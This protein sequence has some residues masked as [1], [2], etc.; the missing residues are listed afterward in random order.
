[1]PVPWPGGGERAIRLLLQLCATLLLVATAAVVFFRITI[2]E[3]GLAGGQ[4]QGGSRSWI[5]KQFASV[6]HI[7][8]LADFFVLWFL[9]VNSLAESG[10]STSGAFI[11]SFFVVPIWA[12]S[13]SIN[14]TGD[15]V[16]RKGP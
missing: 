10:Y 5:Q 9:A 3:W 12:G 11:S 1:M 16:W 8:A 14:A 4:C 6:W 13:G 2:R 7:V 15:A